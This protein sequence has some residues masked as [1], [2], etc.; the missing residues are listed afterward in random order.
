MKRMLLAAGLAVAL[1]AGGYAAAQSFVPGGPWLAPIQA[2]QQ[3]LAAELALD[4][5]QAAAWQAVQRAR[6]EF[7][8]GLRVDVEALRQRVVRDLADPASDLHATAAAIEATVD[9][10][11]AAHRVVR[12]AQLAFYDGLDPAQQAIVRR[13]L[14]ERIERLERLREALADL[15]VVAQ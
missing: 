1:G 10:E 6:V 4:A 8:L 5:R 9:R 3:A 12:D 11:I 14:L 13:H 2:R 7:L 15:A